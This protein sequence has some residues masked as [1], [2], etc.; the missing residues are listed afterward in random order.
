MRGISR[1]LSNF[2]LVLAAT[3]L[4]QAHPT[5]SKPVQYDSQTQPHDR[6]WKVGQEVKTTSGVVVGH[7]SKNR[8]EVSEYLGIPFAKPPVGPLRWAAPQKYNGTGVINASS[9][10]STFIH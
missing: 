9:F 10:V 4:L 1:N 5:F 6:A 8:T 2:V 3:V 7:A